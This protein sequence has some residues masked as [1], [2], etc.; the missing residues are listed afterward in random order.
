MRFM[1]SIGEE[2]LRVVEEIWMDRVSLKCCLKRINSEYGAKG[3][4]LRGVLLDYKYYENSGAKSNLKSANIR[5]DVP[6]G[7]VPLISLTD[8]LKIPDSRL[9]A[10]V[11]MECYLNKTD[12]WIDG[13]N[14]ENQGI[15]EMG[16]RRLINFMGEGKFYSSPSI[17]MFPRM[18]KQRVH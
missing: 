8:N 2:R 14:L 7:L 10:T 11:Q 18:V 1:E 12:Y 16:K 9:R 15:H 6:Y 4:S 5:Q 3:E 13:P 17:R